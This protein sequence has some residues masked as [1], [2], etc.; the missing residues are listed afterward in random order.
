M[1]GLGLSISQ[2]NYRPCA[3]NHTILVNSTIEPMLIT[4][5]LAESMSIYRL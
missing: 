5:H 3:P 1:G 4:V 2:F